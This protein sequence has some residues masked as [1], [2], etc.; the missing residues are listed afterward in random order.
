MALQVRKTRALAWLEDSLKQGER[1]ARALDQ[2]HLIQQ[3]W[4]QTTQRF[5]VMFGENTPEM[6][7]LRGI[8]MPSAHMTGTATAMGR[9]H[10][11]RAHAI[12]QALD[13]IRETYTR[14]ERMPDDAP[15]EPPLNENHAIRRVLAVLYEHRRANPG[16]AISLHEGSHLLDR[17]GLEPSVQRE[18]LETLKRLGYA[19]SA[20]GGGYRISSQGERASRK[21]AL[22]DDDFPIDAESPPP[23]PPAIVLAPAPA[24][25][26]VPAIDVSWVTDA[27]LRAVLERDV[28]ELRT[29]IANRMH[30]TMVVLAGAIAEGLLFFALSARR[31]VAEPL[32]AQ[33]FQGRNR[34]VQPFERWD[35]WTYIEVA[36]RMNVF[37]AAT[38]ALAHDVIRDFRNMIHPKVQLERNLVPT[39]HAADGSVV[40]LRALIEDVRNLQAPAP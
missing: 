22:L 2:A 27:D 7:S 15:I 19:D 24:R 21:P 36:E 30:T 20:P 38:K 5:W 4:L 13:L 1:L 40:W 8:Q 14:T 35:L 28:G 18:H 6:K 29:A 31:A 39:E 3:W 23:P 33:V 12:D 34:R 9:M 16:K 26:P 32:G 17:T 10:E 25:A 11:E 37:Q